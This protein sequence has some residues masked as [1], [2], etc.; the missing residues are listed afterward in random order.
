M[1]YLKSA[2]RA[3]LSSFICAL[4]LTGP[5]SADPAQIKAYKAAFPGEKPKCALCH[6]LAVPTK[7][8][9]DLNDYGKLAVAKQPK[10]DADTY[11]AIGKSQ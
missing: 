11:K 5:A 8:A 2:V 10:P 4:A 7:K 6:T 9:H 3:A 1:I